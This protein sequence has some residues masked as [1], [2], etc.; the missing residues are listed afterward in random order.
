MDPFPSYGAIRAQ[1]GGPRPAGDPDTCRIAL[2]CK[3]NVIPACVS[4]AP[5]LCPLLIPAHRVREGRGEGK[6]HRSCQCRAHTPG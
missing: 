3:R 5:W 4:K 1:A 6:W 2:P